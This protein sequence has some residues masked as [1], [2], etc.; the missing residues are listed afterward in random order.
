[1]GRGRILKLYIGRK[2]KF[3]NWHLNLQYLS[4]TSHMDDPKYNANLM[5]SLIQQKSLDATNIKV[6]KNPTKIFVFWM[7]RKIAAL[8]LYPRKKFN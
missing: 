8:F 1:M 3:P 5:K 7:M 4:A 2:F 6:Q